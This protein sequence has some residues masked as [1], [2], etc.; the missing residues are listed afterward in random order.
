MSQQVANRVTDFVCRMTFRRDDAARSEEY[1]GQ[2][3]YFCSAACHE[4][5]TADRAYFARI[6]TPTPAPR[7]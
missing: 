6:A 7:R 4:Q 2:T 5:F 3:F 1:E